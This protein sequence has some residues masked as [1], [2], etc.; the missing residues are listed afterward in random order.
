M[1]NLKI[2]S[3]SLHKGW[4]IPHPCGKYADWWK[5]HLVFLR[6]DDDND[7]DDD[8]TLVMMRTMTMTMTMMM[9]MVMMMMVM[10]VVVLMM[11]MMMMMMIMMMMVIHHIYIYILKVHRHGISKIRGASA[12]PAQS[13]V[14]VAP[15]M[16]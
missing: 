2:A 6:A 3:A 16:F 1:L 9:M 14:R 5:H 7:D 12:I 8:E 10:M 13:H 4:T 11:T 15:N